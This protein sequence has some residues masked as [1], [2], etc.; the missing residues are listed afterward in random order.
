MK[1][2]VCRDTSVPRTTYSEGLT[3]ALSLSFL[4]NKRF[5]PQASAAQGRKRHPI[6]AAPAGPGFESRPSRVVLGRSLKAP[7]AEG[8]RVMVTLGREIAGLLY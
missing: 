7:E 3:A 1:E 2:L 4:C 6:S 5:L 8:G